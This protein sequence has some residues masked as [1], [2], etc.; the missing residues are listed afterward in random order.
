MALNKEWK[1]YEF[2]DKK[3]LEEARKVKRDQTKLL[4]E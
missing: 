1:E 3:E 4:R 2:M